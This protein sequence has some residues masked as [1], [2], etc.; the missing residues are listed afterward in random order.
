MSQFNTESIVG[1]SSLSNNNLNNE[2][3]DNMD[4]LDQLNH[5]YDTNLDN[6]S[7]AY[8]EVSLLIIIAI[9]IFVM[10]RDQFLIWSDYIKLQ[11]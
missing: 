8:E 10:L 1:S 5:Y 11:Q 2:V 4:P 9:I 7:S 6:E 3:N